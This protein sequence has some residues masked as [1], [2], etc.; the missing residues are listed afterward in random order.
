MSD[1]KII[2]TVVDGVKIV[3]TTPHDITFGVPGTDEAVSVPSSSLVNAKAVETLVETRNGVDFVKTVFTK[4][5][6]GEEVIKAVKAEEP[7]AVIVGSIVAAQA[8]PGEVVGM[9]PMPGFERVAPAEKRMNP[10]K[11]TIFS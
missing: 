4:T 1:I 9:T 11:F 10:H 5:P 8:F 6:E 7:D 3:N 2:V